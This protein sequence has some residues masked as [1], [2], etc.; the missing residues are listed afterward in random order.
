MLNQLKLSFIFLSAV[1]LANMAMQPTFA[2]NADEFNMPHAAMRHDEHTYTFAGRCPNGEAYRL[3]SY[4]M[5]VDG[6]ITSFYDYQ[7]P[8]GNGTIR[9]ETTPKVM[10]V[11][12]CH[13]LAELINA[14]Y[15]E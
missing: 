9:A 14:N 15:W 12:V 10:A 4:Q 6:L 5:D 13:P 2:A 3:Q 8:V 11:R 7:G 1:L